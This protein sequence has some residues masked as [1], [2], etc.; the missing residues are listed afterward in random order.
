MY[1]A[2]KSLLSLFFAKS[3][4]TTLEIENQEVF[5]K[6]IERR[7]IV[8][9]LFVRIFCGRFLFAVIEKS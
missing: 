3:Q 4:Y 5:P 6:N 8:L 1:D 9:L 2:R 7:G